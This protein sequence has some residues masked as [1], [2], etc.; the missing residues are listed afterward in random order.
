MGRESVSRYASL[1]DRANLYS[2]LYGKYYMTEKTN[3]ASV[4]YGFKKHLETEHYAVY[5]NQYMLPFVKTADA[6]YS[7]SELDRCPLLRKNRRC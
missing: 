7:E 2:L 4:P 3:E 1:G 6:I 5:E